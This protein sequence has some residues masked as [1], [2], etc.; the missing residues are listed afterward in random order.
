MLTLAVR[1]SDTTAAAQAIQGE[2]DRRM[3]GEQ[4]LL[5]VLEMSD[6]A[7]ELAAQWIRDEHP[8][9]SPNLITRELI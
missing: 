3:T 9:W 8:D 7:R 2:I 1:M 6:F 4:H 5:L